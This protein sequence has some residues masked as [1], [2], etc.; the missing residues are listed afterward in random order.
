MKRL[1]SS[2]LISLLLL[3]QQLNAT[4][5]DAP[6][7]TWIGTWA[8]APQPAI[9]SLVQ[10][11]RNQTLRLIVHASA[12]G[13]EVRIKVSNTYG[14]QPLVIGAAHIA[15]RTSG[16]DIDPA[17][18][19]ILTFGRHPST[20]IPARSMTVSDPVDLA[21]PPLSDLAISLFLPNATEA[22]TT[23]ILAVQTN[24]VSAETG[25]ATAAVKF[26]VQK[27]ITSWPFL[28]GVDVAASPH[29]AAIV[30]FGSS[31]TDGD[32]ST[33]DANHRW[34]DVLAERLQKNGNHDAELG[35][36]N[37]GIIGNRL[38][39]D[40]H[41][42]RQAGG[43]FE[44]AF[45]RYG[46]ALGEAGLAR[47]DRDVLE[48][49][50]VRYVILALGV[51]DMLFPGSFIPAAESVTAES[52]ISGN[53]QLIARAH[54]NGIRVIE[55]TI[56]PFENATF[57]HPVISF[58]TPEKEAVRQ[59]VNAWIRSSREFDSVIDFDEIL[60]DPSHPS[61]LLPKFDSGDHLHPNDA[62]YIACGNAIQL[63]LFH[64]SQ[65]IKSRKEGS[66]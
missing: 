41:S 11:F 65:P 28:T 34:P 17:S 5:P 58:Y 39:S 60:R 8:T 15:R 38:L 64:D 2:F 56:P 10:T 53:R 29:G 51:N 1:P 61:Q 31:T 50:G 24:Y 26:S 4:P 18:D 13:A 40:S 19:R 7:N 66:R 23:H 35:V 52:V 21:V 45:K 22:T 9:P 6:Q 44:T 30:A 16:A 42:P 32:G 57:Q 3:I 25:D 63:V 47:F 12:G 62:G 46:D 36:L 43:P 37:E 14:D 55:T 49:A 48:Q 27:T 33:D 54:K 59:E 20:T